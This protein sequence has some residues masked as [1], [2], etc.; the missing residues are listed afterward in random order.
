MRNWGNSPWPDDGAIPPDAGPDMHVNAKRR[1]WVA[2]VDTSIGT[3]D[4]SHPAIYLEGQ[5]DTPNMRGFWTLAS[6]IPTPGA[7]SAATSA[8][9]AGAAGDADATAQAGLTG[10]AGQAAL[11]GDAGQAGLTGDA[12]QAGLTGDAGQAAESCTNGFECCSGFCEQGVCA[13]VSTITC[14]GLGHS[15]TT[16]ADCCNAGVVV[17]ANGTCAVPAAR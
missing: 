8:L 5:D 15:C 10:D 1:L 11:T 12:G 4:P 7:I 2:A 16:A 13:D 6:C 9:D 3:V 14:V 17:C